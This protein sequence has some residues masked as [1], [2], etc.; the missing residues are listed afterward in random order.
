M[1]LGPK[2]MLYSIL[3]SNVIVSLSAMFLCGGFTFFL[4]VD[5]WCFYALFT[6]I[7]T[8]TVYNGQR[9]FKSEVRE[10]TAWLF[11]VERNKKALW[12]VVLSLGFF[13][14]F[15]FFLLFSF[16]LIAGLVFFISAFVSVFYVVKLGKISLREIPYI[17]IHLIAIIWVLVL[18][19]FPLI[20]EMFFLKC[21]YY[22]LP[23]YLY[24][25]GVTI[26]FDVRDLKHDSKNQKTIP[27]LLGVFGAKSLAVSCLVSFAF[28]MCF[29]DFRFTHNY[30][31]FVAIIIQ[32]TLVLYTNELRSEIYFAGLIDGAISILGVSYFFA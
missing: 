26:P 28:L 23:H 6:G 19:V 1:W 27:Q 8:M 20:N 13:S 24:I 25:L 14:F 29:I 15:L 9:L 22:A 7:S 3:Y 2:K 32:I 30:I 31:F 11:W 17:K 10:K 5:D 16:E 21:F 18:L 12:C 4:G